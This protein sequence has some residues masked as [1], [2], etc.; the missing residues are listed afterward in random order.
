[1]VTV[2]RARFLFAVVFVDAVLGLRAVVEEVDA[3]PPP[4]RVGLVA[5][6]R[7]GAVEEVVFLGGMMRILVR[8]RA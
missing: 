1:M 6:D 7:L 8:T 3:R 2:S 4:P 5:V